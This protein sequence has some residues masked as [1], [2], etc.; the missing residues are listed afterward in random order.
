MFVWKSDIY[1][2][3]TYDTRKKI[4]LIKFYGIQSGGCL[5][6]RAVIITFFFPSCVCELFLDFIDRYMESKKN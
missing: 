1:D 5:E 6:K 4:L 3:K 2:L